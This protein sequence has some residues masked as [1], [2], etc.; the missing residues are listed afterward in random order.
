[1][2]C[3]II[4]R[5]DEKCQLL[6]YSPNMCFLGQTYF[7]NDIKFPK[8]IEGEGGGSI[9]I[10]QHSTCKG[11]VCTRA[12]IYMRD[13]FKQTPWV[14]SPWRQL[15][16]HCHSIKTWK[17]KHEHRNLSSSIYLWGACLYWT[18][19]MNKGNFFVTP[20]KWEVCVC[21]WGGGDLKTHRTLYTPSFN[22]FW[23]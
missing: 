18:S 12:R 17:L 1:M 8:A 19:Y 16:T 22:I 13:G 4:H 15:L 10:N 2:S 23:R 7:G 5:E 11:G 6:K 20:I 3:K 9:G 21:V 14:F